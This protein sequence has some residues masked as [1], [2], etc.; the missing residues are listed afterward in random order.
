MILPMLMATPAI[1]ARS[2]I[3][4]RETRTRRSGRR[5]A[6]REGDASDLVRDRRALVD[7]DAEIAVD[8]LLACAWRPGP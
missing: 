6:A 4:V 8:D 5:L 1:R 7:V 2:E 3:S